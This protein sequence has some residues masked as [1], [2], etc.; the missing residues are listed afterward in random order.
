M[1]SEMEGFERVEIEPVTKPDVMKTLE[2]I[3]PGKSAL[4]TIEQMGTLDRLRGV[5]V[6]AKKKGVVVRLRV[7]DSGKAYE[8]GRVE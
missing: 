4:F 5:M 7:L 6:R 1:P 8:I 3:P 2:K